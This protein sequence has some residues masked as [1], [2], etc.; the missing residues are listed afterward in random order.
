M[1]P[2]PGRSSTD[3]TI[4]EWLNRYS[5]N[6]TNFFTTLTLYLRTAKF[7]IQPQ[8]K[9]CCFPVHSLN[10]SPRR[11]HFLRLSSRTD[12][13][14]PRTRTTGPRGPL[15]WWAHRRW[16]AVCLHPA[17]PE[18]LLADHA[19]PGPTW[20]DPLTGLRDPLLTIRA[21]RAFNTTTG[22]DHVRMVSSYCFFWFC[23]SWV[24]WVAPLLSPLLQHFVILLRLG[25]LP[26]VCSMGIIYFAVI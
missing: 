20:A 7:F 9:V 8:N 13:R 16:E 12:S 26:I 19:C 10:L 18:D 25:L 1:P 6:L 3:F 21:H 5:E 15:W 14:G 2:K 22:T 4:T 17:C 23:D 24:L 11:G